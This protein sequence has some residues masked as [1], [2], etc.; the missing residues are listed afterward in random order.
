MPTPELSDITTHGIRV[1]ATAYFLP[2]ESEPEDR[3]YLFGY[4]IVIKNDGAI[5]CAI[6]RI[7]GY[8]RL[9]IL[10]TSHSAGAIQRVLGSLRNSKQLVSNDRIAIDVDPISLL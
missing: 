5:P 10:L 2:E 3:K 7:A 4:T 8:I 1:A 6:G 9:Q